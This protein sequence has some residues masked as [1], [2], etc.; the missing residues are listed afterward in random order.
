MIFQLRLFTG[1][2][3][4]HKPDRIV[5]FTSNKCQNN[6]IGY[7]DQLAL[8]GN[9]QSMQLLERHF[10]GREADRDYGYGRGFEPVIVGSA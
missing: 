2:A 9:F 1:N 10:E 6:P 8:S 3:T 7:A 5:H 4:G